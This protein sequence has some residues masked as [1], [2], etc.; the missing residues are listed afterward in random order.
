MVTYATIQEV[1]NYTN[2]LG[3]EYSDTQLT[4]ILENITAMIDQ[5]TG[6]T[7]QAVQTA[8]NE[9]YDGSGKRRLFLKRMDVVALTAISIDED[10]NGVFTTVTPTNVDIY[11]EEGILH[12]QEDAEVTQFSR[13]HLN[14]K[15]T[16]TYGSATV[17]NMVRNLTLIMIANQLDSTEDKQMK[18]DSLIKNLRAVGAL[19]V[20]NNI[21]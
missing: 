19:Q 20:V 15:V 10:G 8:T 12:L 1:R 13:G 11:K 7:W 18:I 21:W 2:V 5:L 9:L 6:R 4:L 17:P 16:Y 3:P 14:V